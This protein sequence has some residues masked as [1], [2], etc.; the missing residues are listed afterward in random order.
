M[1]TG[2]V[3][4]PFAMEEETYLPWSMDLLVWISF[5]QEPQAGDAWPD[6]GRIVF[7][8]IV[9]FRETLGVEELAARD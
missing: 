3:W 2:L 8:P 6:G 5:Y 7:S 1:A 9:H 4:E